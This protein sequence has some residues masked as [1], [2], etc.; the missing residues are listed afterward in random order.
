MVLKSARFGMLLLAASTARAQQA[1]PVPVLT[2]YPHEIIRADMVEERE[3]A[4]RLAGAGAFVEDSG[5]LI[6]KA[7]RVTLLPGKPI[8]V[9]AIEEP[10][11][12]RMGAQVR[13]VFSR[14]GVT[15][16]GI[17]IA[18]E[19]GGRGERIRVRNADSSSGAVKDDGS[20]EVGDL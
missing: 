17:G 7:A 19:A 8:P 10:R 20:V 14:D 5:K 4:Y 13:I 2:I 12:V 15:I 6:G 9:N 16:I 1:A 3:L 11:I 18:L